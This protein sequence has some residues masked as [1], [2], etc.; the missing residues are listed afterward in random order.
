MP[1]DV[2]AA[3]T[4]FLHEHQRCG[5]LDGGRE[6]GLIWLSCT[7]GAQIVYPAPHQEKMK[8]CNTQAGEKKGDE[9]KAFNK[10]M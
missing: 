8:A 7:C 4:A 10:K 2:L 9:R 6:N 5:E 1:E 3:L